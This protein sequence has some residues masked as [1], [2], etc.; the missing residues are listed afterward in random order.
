MDPNKIRYDVYTNDELSVIDINIRYPDQK[1]KLE[2][3]C[4]PRLGASNVG[5]CNLCYFNDRKCKGHYGKLTT[6]KI[7]PRPTIIGS[8]VFNKF[9]KYICPHCWNLKFKNIT[10]EDISKLLLQKDYIRDI[11]LLLKNKTSS[12]CL[13][14]TCKEAGNGKLIFIKKTCKFTITF[15]NK[16][17]NSEL[18]NYKTIYKYLTSIPNFIYNLFNIYIN[19]ED[20]FFNNNII[21]PPKTIRPANIFFLNEQ[22]ENNDITKLICHIIKICNNVDTSE[23]LI[24]KSLQN[25]E[26]ST[27]KNNKNNYTYYLKYNGLYKKSIVGN[28]T[29]S[30]IWLVIVSEATI[31]VGEIC[32]P[33]HAS[34]ISK[35]IYV[36]WITKNK[37]EYYFN[38]ATDYYKKS[39]GTFI[40]LK[41]QKF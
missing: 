33:K 9:L 39:T 5:L 19:P 14:S 37:L 1:N 2:S 18:I 38:L 26:S 24:Y 40:N 8:R 27:E 34:I 11:K 16:N 10:D 30:S 28:R 15:S 7:I 4:D 13:R 29:N 6:D 25:L 32:L 22:R 12:K 21:I 23:E 36:N 35:R 3:S 20:F 17:K 41:D 31:K